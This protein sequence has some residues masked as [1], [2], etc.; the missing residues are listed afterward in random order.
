MTTNPCTPCA[1]ASRKSALATNFQ[2]GVTHASKSETF[3]FCTCAPLGI[4]PQRIT[5]ARFIWVRAP[6][7]NAP[8]MANRINPYIASAERRVKYHIIISKVRPRL[9][10]GKVLDFIAMLA[11][12]RSAEN[13][14]NSDSINRQED[15][16]FDPDRLA[17]I[18]D[19]F[20]PQIK[21]RNPQTVDRMEQRA[22]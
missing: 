11:S 13:H 20:W 3:V 12:R 2:K 9:E 16:P 7:I 8:I 14:K 21:N 1:V 19:Q 4:K 5:S 17:L 18:L 22:K 6:M 15:R 10:S